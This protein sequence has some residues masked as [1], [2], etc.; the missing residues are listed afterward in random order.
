MMIL[1]ELVKHG[2]IREDQV[3]EIVKTADEKYNGDLDKALVNFNISE[4]SI[5]ELRGSI[6]NIPI[7]KV[8]PTLITDSV[9]KIIPVETAKTYH[10]VPIGVVNDVLEIGIIDP[11]NVQAIDVLTFITAKLDKPF[12]LFQN[13]IKKL[14]MRVKGCPL[15]RVLIKRRMKMLQKMHQ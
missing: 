5:L 2:L 7:K 1:E 13:L 4:D 11:E 6:F 15:M 9:L 10:F 14:P 8:D 12:K 3:P